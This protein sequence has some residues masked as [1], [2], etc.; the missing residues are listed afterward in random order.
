[1]TAKSQVKL[2][3]DAGKWFH[4]LDFVCVI[5]DVLILL[6]KF[7]IYFWI[8]FYRN[9]VTFLQGFSFLFFMTLP[10]RS[11][12]K[13]K[14]TKTEVQWTFVNISLFLVAQ[15]HFLCCR[16]N[17]F[18]SEEP[19]WLQFSL[20]VILYV[21]FGKFILLEW[22]PACPGD[23]CS[24][25][26]GTSAW[27]ASPGTAQVPFQPT[28][29]DLS[30]A[31]PMGFMMKMLW[32]AGNSNVTELVTPGWTWH[33]SLGVRFGSRALNLEQNVYCFPSRDFI[34][35]HTEINTLPGAAGNL[36]EG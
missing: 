22:T 1:M 16:W 14:N 24:H 28:A 23:A 31:K 35:H 21:R 32:R 17:E 9:K 20:W 29:G 2:Q 6:Q 8:S 27:A 5:A 12:L 11:P 13:E 18:V 19:Q 25:P 4:Y 36:R 3:P 34:M 15:F 26:T 30:P 33:P 10:I 7:L